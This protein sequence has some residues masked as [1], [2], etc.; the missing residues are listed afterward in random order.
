MDFINTP[1]I[2]TTY[3]TIYSTPDILF[4]LSFFLTEIWLCHDWDGFFY[5]EV[6]FYA[7][8]YAF[9][10]LRTTHDVF[11]FQRLAALSLFCFLQKIVCFFSGA[12]S[13]DSVMEISSLYQPFNQSKYRASV[14]FTKLSCHWMKYSLIIQITQAQA[15]IL[16]HTSILASNSSHIHNTFTLKREQKRHEKQVSNCT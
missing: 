1:C 3:D 8:F 10:L 13:Y 5:I 14:S 9:F 16:Y 7:V 11:T 15:N 4:F 6:A 12:P 2:F